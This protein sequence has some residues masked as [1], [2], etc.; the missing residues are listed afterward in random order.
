MMSRGRGLAHE[1]APPLGR[2]GAAE[3]GAGI[4]D[5]YEDLAEDIVREGGHGGG[6]LLHIVPL[7]VL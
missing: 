1:D 7:V 2:H 3:E 4:G 5:V 6:R